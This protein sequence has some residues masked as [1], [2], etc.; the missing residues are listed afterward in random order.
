MNNYTKGSKPITVLWHLLKPDGTPFNLNGYDLELYYY[1]GR[2]KQAA[3]GINATDNALAWLF[4]P[5]E[6]IFE[7][8]YSLELNIIQSGKLLCRLFYKDAFSLSCRCFVPNR[9]ETHVGES[10]EVVSLFT[11]AEFYQFSP[12]IPVLDPVSGYWFVNGE[13]TGVNGRTTCEMLE[14]GTLIFDKG[15]KT[16]FEH[17]GF[18]DAFAKIKEWEASES[19]RK[20]NESDRIANELARSSAE[21]TRK[22]AEAARV[23]AESQR[24]AAETERKNAETQRVNAETQRR[25]AES[26]RVSAE[27]RRV[28]SETA[29]QTSETARQKGETARISA[30]RDRQSGYSNMLAVFGDLQTIL[31]EILG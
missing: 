1:V 8:P 16:E 25:T 29:R 23:T 19:T 26:A 30:E 22:T 17:Y 3:T 15:M 2:G 13:S 7:G 11:T 4:M 10:N 20:K 24:K 5:D 18:R 14:D 6:Q 28:S 27:N 31:A 21:S 12:V 9:K